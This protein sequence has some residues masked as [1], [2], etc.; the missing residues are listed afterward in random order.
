MEHD[1]CEK[2]PSHEATRLPQERRIEVNPESWK[3]P[4]WSAANGVH[5]PYQ[6]EAIKKLPGVLMEL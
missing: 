4:V 2:H 1:T 5:T 3:K 6:I